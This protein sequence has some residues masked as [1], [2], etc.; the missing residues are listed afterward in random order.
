MAIRLRL[1]RAFRDIAGFSTRNQLSAASG[2]VA[3]VAM[4]ENTIGFR[5]TSPQMTSNCWIGNA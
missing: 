3:M 4:I 5:L 2:R 1:R